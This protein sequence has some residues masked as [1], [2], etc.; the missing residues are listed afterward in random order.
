MC[1]CWLWVTVTFSAGLGTRPFGCALLKHRPVGRPGP[2]QSIGV[3]PRSPTNTAWSWL[4]RGPSRGYAMW[5]AQELVALS[6]LAIDWR[7]A[8]AVAGLEPGHP[9]VQQDSGG[10]P[11]GRIGAG[12]RQWTPSQ[13]LLRHH[14]ES[15]WTPLRA[16]SSWHVVSSLVCSGQIQPVSN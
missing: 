3:C 13:R 16:A 6:G 5:S 14:R 10:S 15:I 9:G 12:C 11:G 7:V 4:D 2:L 1:A 8:G